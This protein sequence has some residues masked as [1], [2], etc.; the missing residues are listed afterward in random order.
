[1]VGSR[2]SACSA[3]PTGLAPVGGFFSFGHGSKPMGSH[4]GIG[5][6]PILVFLFSGDWDAHRSHGVLTH[7]HM[8]WNSWGKPQVLAFGFICQGA[9]LVHVFEPQ[10]YG[11]PRKWLA[12][13]FFVFFFFLGVLL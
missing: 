10:P 11:D 6:P 13:P 4:F 8:A 12:S 2:L 7:G 3:L 1:M 9:M 5:A